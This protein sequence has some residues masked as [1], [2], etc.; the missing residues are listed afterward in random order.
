MKITICDRCKKILEN[1]EII[2]VY[3]HNRILEVCKECDF[4][5]KD[6]KKEY[7][8]KMT[9][10]DNKYHKLAKEFDNKINT[11]LEERN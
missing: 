10:L 2:K 1:E 9:K 4:I 11:V 3:L 6:I 7:E 8:D 5:I